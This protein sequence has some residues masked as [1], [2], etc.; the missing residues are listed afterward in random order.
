MHRMVAERI[1]A[2][3]ANCHKHAELDVFLID[4]EEQDSV[5]R[6]RRGLMVDATCKR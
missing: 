3:P 2:Y 4:F 5:V 6:R 1:V